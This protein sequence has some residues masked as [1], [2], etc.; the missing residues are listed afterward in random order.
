VTDR[1]VLIALAFHAND[2]TWESF[3]AVRTMAAMTGL[4]TN[5]VT[6]ALRRL[7]E[8]Q[9]IEIVRPGDRH[10]STIYRLCRDQVAT[11]TEVDA[12]EPVS[13]SDRD[14][15]VAMV[16]QS[17]RDQVATELEQNT[18]NKPTDVNDPREA[19]VIDFASLRSLTRKAAR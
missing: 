13:Q 16:S 4:S 14:T 1:I 11:P 10:R 15:G 17:C 12:V 7:V 5:T 8:S 2:Q 19:T 6:A 3:P 9:L 18:T